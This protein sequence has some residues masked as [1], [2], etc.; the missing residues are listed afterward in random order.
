MSIASRLCALV[1]L[2]TMPLLTA[3]TSTG[4]TSREFELQLAGSPQA[5]DKNS[6]LLAALDQP[7]TL[8][9]ADTPLR[10]ALTLI[11]KQSALP[12]AVD[13]DALRD[14]DMKPKTLVTLQLANAPV[15]EAF[16]MLFR[17][18]TAPDLEETSAVWIATDGVV[19]VG[20]V[21]SLLPHRKTISYAVADIL[22]GL[23]AD[24][25][26]EPDPDKAKATATTA[27]YRV[28]APTPGD[29]SNND[30]DADAVR[31]A[32]FALIE[33]ASDVRPELWDSHDG[34]LC[35]MNETAGVLVL[36][37]PEEV[38]R[39]VFRALIAVRAAIQRQ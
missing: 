5:L 35:V 2:L 13:W 24:T 7:I 25:V 9:F 38:H 30:E 23:D 29:D 10:E 39:R 33:N 19:V 14:T 36:T 20:T 18:I 1:L 8:D 34:T 6:K 31:D 26:P 16:N 4:A 12:M 37:A 3:C 32:L 15:R 17:S 28:A 11:A 22:D 27:M 21:K